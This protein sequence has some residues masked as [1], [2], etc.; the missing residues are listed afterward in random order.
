MTATETAEWRAMAGRHHSA[1]SAGALRHEYTGI[2]R[3]DNG[4]RL[5]GVPRRWSFTPRLPTTGLEL[6]VS[7]HGQDTL[8]NLGDE[9]S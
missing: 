4:T 8:R 7:Q 9:T 5:D 3:S 6:V 2:L 1:T